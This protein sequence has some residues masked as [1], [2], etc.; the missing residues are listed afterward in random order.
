MTDSSFFRLI[1]VILIATRL[2]EC[3]NERDVIFLKLFGSKDQMKVGETLDL[4]KQLQDLDPT[5]VF[6]DLVDISRVSSEKC[7]EPSSLRLKLRYMES[8]I[9]T[10]PWTSNSIKVYV[11]EYRKNQ[12]AVCQPIVRQ[13]LQNFM[14]TIADDMLDSVDALIKN[15]KKM[16]LN[17]LR[18]APRN[19]RISATSRMLRERG[20]LHDRVQMQKVLDDLTKVCKTI[21]GHVGKA[22]E[23]FTL[24]TSQDDLL[25]QIDPLLVRWVERDILCTDISRD[26]LYGY[27]TTMK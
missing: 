24:W 3:M 18:T 1:I 17:T 10:S 5:P 27:D 22:L 7:D 15:L 2:A 16:Q 11:D 23:F 6:K 20:V 25:R 9:A 14:D 8:R 13:A 19:L 12:F 4:L 21:V 26:Y